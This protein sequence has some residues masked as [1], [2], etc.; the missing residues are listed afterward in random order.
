ME[1]YINKL[2]DLED[3]LDLYSYGQIWETT[4][5]GAAKETTVKE[6]TNLDE[7]L[8]K[9][10]EVDGGIPENESEEVTLN[11][12]KRYQ[13]LVKSLKEKN[14]FKCQICGYTFTMNNGNG[15]CEAHHINWL[16]TGGTQDAT[17]VVIVCANH[18]R[19]FHYATN[20]ITIGEVVNDKRVINIGEESYIVNLN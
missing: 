6:D 7:D 13:K 2:Y 18:H 11:R 19:M 5:H 3:V 9:E 14:D 8:R 10:L 16:S 4:L 20:L 1:E 17:N 12:I 15:Y